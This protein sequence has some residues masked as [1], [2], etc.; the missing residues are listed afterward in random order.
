MLYIGWFKFHRGAFEKALWK[1]ATPE[2]KVILVTLLGMVN[3]SPNEW[4]FKGEK[5][6]AEPG[7]MITSLDSIVKECGKG[8]SIKNVRTALTK[9]KKLGFLAYEA[10]NDGTLL[11]IVNW[12][13]YQS[14]EDEGGKANGKPL[15]NGGQ[16]GGK[17]VATI[18]E[19]KEGKKDQEGKNK[20]IADVID[21]LNKTAGKK[22]K[23]GT[24]GNSK[25]I[26]ARLSEGA[27]FDDFCHVVDVK[28]AQWIN[29]L[30]QNKFLRPET[31]FGNK[32]DGY[33]NES[34]SNFK[35]NNHQRADN[36]GVPISNAPEPTFNGVPDDGA[37]K[38]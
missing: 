21:Y 15:A 16:T 1:T 38:F 2:Q 27:T 24:V 3:F 30:D 26:K 31:L 8:I 32:F 25:F 36:N 34:K 9:F 18:E 5:Y 29:K 17:Q 20:I 23:A 22:F 4:L 19:G 14:N 10:A 11:T 6:V 33:L 12:E 35:V 13:L 37:I 28:T 7:Q